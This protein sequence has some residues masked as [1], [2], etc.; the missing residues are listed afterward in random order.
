VIKSRWL[1][2][3]RNAARVGERRGTYRVL[4]RIPEGKKPIERPG[5]R[6]EDNSKIGRSGL[7]QGQVAGCFECGN[8]PLGSIK[9][10]TFLD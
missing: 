5:H 7:G 10:A 3:A 2:W 6:W 9:C 4:V 8:E 1:R